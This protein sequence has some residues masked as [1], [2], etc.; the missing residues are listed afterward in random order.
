MLGV[1]I[2]L[3]WLYKNQNENVVDSHAEDFSLHPDEI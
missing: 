1:G 3:F 2:G